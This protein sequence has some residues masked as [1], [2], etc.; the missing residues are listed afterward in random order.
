MIPVREQV[1]VDALEKMPRR[2]CQEA[3]GACKKQ[4]V[5]GDRLGAVDRQAP[6]FGGGP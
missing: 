1:A 3:T 5:A 2:Q 6:K 4:S